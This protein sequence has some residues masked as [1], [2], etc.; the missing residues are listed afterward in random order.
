MHKRLR[1]QN[2]R[3]CI[4]AKKNT[5]DLMICLPKRN[6]ACE[7]IQQEPCLLNDFQKHTPL[8]RVNHHSNSINK[9]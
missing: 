3:L 9:L 1:K 2:N 7:K 4:R 6:N 5:Y 8:V